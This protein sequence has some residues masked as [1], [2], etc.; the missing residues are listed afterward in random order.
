MK[1][2]LF[3]LKKETILKS[4]HVFRKGDATIA[5][6]AQSRGFMVGPE[7]LAQEKSKAN[8]DPSLI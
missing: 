8:N 7:K 1:S 4:K 3:L 6:S 5:G 2:N